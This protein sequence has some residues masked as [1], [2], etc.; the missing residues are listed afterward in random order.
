[1]RKIHVYSKRC[2]KTEFHQQPLETLW[3]HISPLYMVDESTWL[4]Q[5]LPLAMPSEQEKLAIENQTTDL[6]KAIRADKK[7]VQMIDALLLEYS[8]DTHEGILLMCLAEALMRIPDA[9][10]AD[11]LIRDKL[12]VADWKSHLKIPIRFCE[13]VYLGLDADW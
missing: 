6:I 12:S 2:T 4:K 8:L 10:T 1:M 3:S 5:L 13:R 7:S 9:A 11:A